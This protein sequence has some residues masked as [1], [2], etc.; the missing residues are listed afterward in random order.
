MKAKVSRRS[1]IGGAVVA[2]AAVASAPVL[3]RE[4]GGAA[5][6]TWAGSVT[7]HAAALK[8][9]YLAELERFAETL[10][11]R[12]ESGELRAFRSPGDDYNREK[13]REDYPQEKLERL[14]ATHFGLEETGDKGEGGDA[15]AAYA[16]LAASPRAE[17]TADEGW[18]H[19]IYHAANAVGW[20]VIAL[21]R[22]RGW[23]TPGRDEEEDPIIAELCPDCGD[24]SWQHEENG[25]HG[26]DCNCLRG[27]TPHVA[28]W[29]S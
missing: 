6:K 28:G 2:G 12:F 20:D 13:G 21:A 18:N 24:Y 19:P 1:F 23:Y 3:G 11:P 15:A 26:G 16:I 14:L 5:G 25:C 10:R 17:V 29:L 27:H 4:K 9:A 8:A 7:A 22:A